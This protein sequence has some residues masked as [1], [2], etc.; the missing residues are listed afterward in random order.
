MSFTIGPFRVDVSHRSANQGIVG[1]FFNKLVANGGLLGQQ[2]IAIGITLALSIVATVVIA[3]VVKLVIGL[4][5]TPES[6]T[7]GLDITDHGEEGYDF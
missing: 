4:R 5:P 7:A 2:L 6:E 1:A 3:L